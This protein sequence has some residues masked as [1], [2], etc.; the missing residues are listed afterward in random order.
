MYDASELKVKCKNFLQNDLPSR[1]IPELHFLYFILKT[2]EPS[3]DLIDATNHLAE[4]YLQQGFF[5]QTEKILK[6]NLKNEDLILPEQRIRTNILLADVMHFTG[7]LEEAN[8]FIK[9]SNQLLSEIPE[10][11][12][13]RS[14][15]YTSISNIKFLEGNYTEAEVNGE[16]ALKIAIELD[17]K[18]IIGKIYLIL[19][20]IAWAN[21]LIT[22]AAK[23]FNDSITILL[24]AKKKHILAETYLQCGAFVGELTVRDELKKIDSL[25][26]PAAYYINQARLLFNESGSLYDMERVYNYFRFYGRR[27]TDK[28]VEENISTKAQEITKNY[29]ELSKSFDTFSN[30][31][32][33]IFNGKEQNI[34]PEIKDEI[35]AF[36]DS[37]INYNNVTREHQLKLY[38]LHDRLMESSHS[39]VL[40]R[41]HYLGVLDGVRR[42]G[43]IG[44]YNKLL[45]E[46]VKQ[47]KIILDADRVI[48]I[49]VDNIDK[50]TI[51]SQCGQGNQDD[52]YWQILAERSNNLRKS[53]MDTSQTENYDNDDVA[54]RRRFAE[55]GKAI[56]VPVKR[57]NKMIGVIYADKYHRDG[58]FDIKQMHLLESFASQA[59]IL[60]Q[61]KRVTEDLRLSLKSQETTMEAISEGLINISNDGRIQLINSSGARLLGISQK[62]AKGKKFGDIPELRRLIKSFSD[63]YELEGQVIRLFGG[64]VV[65]NAKDIT[66]DNG[67]VIGCIINLTE[68][69]K[70]RNTV[71]KVGGLKARYTFSSI[72]GT[73]PVFIKQLRL[74]ENAAQSDSNVLITGESGTGKEV[75]AQ[76][77]HNASK[78]ASGPF[79]GINCAA[80][81]RDLL[82]SE[83]FGYTEGAFTGAKKGGQPG[84]FEL[85]EGGT[86][87]LDE[88]GDMPIEMQVK[89]LRVLQ[90]RRFERVGDVNTYI[91]DARI[92]ATTNQE[93]EEIINQGRFRND[94]YYRLRVIHLNLPPLRKRNSDISS[95][96]SHFLKHYSQSLGK[97]LMSIS[98]EVIDEFLNYNWPGNIRELEHIIESEINQAA[99]EDLELA[100]VPLSIS[101]YKKPLSSSEIFDDLHFDKL[102]NSPAG[103]FCLLEDAEKD[104]LLNAIKEHNGSPSAIAKSLG[105]SRGSVYNK[106]KKFNIDINVY[107]K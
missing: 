67:D 42:L 75:I 63:I 94:L 71:R 4:C 7:R 45:I 100:T 18:K 15:L 57:E 84:K 53:I 68:M 10:N 36:W 66:E 70:A 95:L 34:N 74:A 62:D 3:T 20:N 24:N 93:I 46:I 12:E 21:G 91:L 9:L 29:R 99:P 107:K 105:I 52:S 106:I 19:A 39:V 61:N 54:S 23:Y 35:L 64:E 80:I 101:N 55:L 40:Q 13:L 14:I 97:Q 33:N 77:I 6:E 8:F 37:A 16:K 44:N 89:L 69:K 72:L 30:S 102:N 104:L 98:Q 96:A 41:D 59:G 76:A 56:A 60:I 25:D 22:N 32:N 1:A 88:I 26:K 82:E 90:E 48:L 17:N 5:K 78:R 81:P 38:Y 92:I 11:K 43:M 50:L 83:L 85:A 49:G 2:S 28:V 51:M 86:I 31:L 79:V 103:N 65:L 87:L 73:S 47:A 27:L 58:L